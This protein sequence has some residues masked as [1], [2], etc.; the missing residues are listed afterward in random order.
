MSVPGR[1]RCAAFP[2]AFH[3]FL[4][5]SDVVETLPL[6]AMSKFHLLAIG[7]RFLWNGETWRKTSPLLAVSETTGTRRLIPRAAV[8]QVLDE[9]AP[10]PRPEPVPLDA[11]T[12]AAA[13]SVHLD[14][15]LEAINAQDIPPEIKT[16]LA[17]ALRASDAAVRRKLSLP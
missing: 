6:L 12:I 3:S 2:L 10:A 11:Q 17:E 5:E 4:Q 13:L 15:C 8:L 9:G 14:T 7:Q 1:P 16:A